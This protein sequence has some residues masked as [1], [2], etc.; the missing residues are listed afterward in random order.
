ME[1][2]KHVALIR[3]IYQGPVGHLREEKLLKAIKEKFWWKKM[4]GNIKTALK[5]CEVCGLVENKRQYQVLK[6]IE[7]SYSFEL[8]LL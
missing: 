1:P 8:V 7:I 6:P 4:R 2:G 5:N 3:R